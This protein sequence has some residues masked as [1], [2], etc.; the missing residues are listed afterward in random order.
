M[1]SG[2]ARAR[3]FHGPSSPCSVPVV[4]PAAVTHALA[5]GRSNVSSRRILETHPRD[6]FSRHI[7]DTTMQESWGT[8]IGMTQHTCIGVTAHMHRRDPVWSQD[9]RPRREAR[10]HDPLVVQRGRGRHDPAARPLA[11][12]V[13]AL[14]RN[15]KEQRARVTSGELWYTVRS[16][17]AISDA[18]NVSRS[19]S[20][21][22]PAVL[23]G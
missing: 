9:P 8:C 1:A 12:L 23:R 21:H 10:W 14:D 6:T 22:V 4:T 15:A 19:R 17:S 11:G 13:P 20:D 5:W 16:E 2:R 18:S 7:L 3:D